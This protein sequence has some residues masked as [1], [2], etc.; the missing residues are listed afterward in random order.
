MKMQKDPLEAD[1]QRLLEW[2]YQTI[3]SGAGLDSEKKSIRRN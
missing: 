2:T 3:K 1:Q